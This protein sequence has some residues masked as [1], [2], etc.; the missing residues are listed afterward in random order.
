MIM[1]GNGHLNLLLNAH[2][3]IRHVLN[4]FTRL[5]SVDAVTTL[6]YMMCASPIVVV[7]VGKHTSQT[8]VGPPMLAIVMCCDSAGSSSGP[9][10]GCTQFI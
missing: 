9:S 7:P 10:E 4:T 1:H 5:D 2:R 6:K 3:S 8:R